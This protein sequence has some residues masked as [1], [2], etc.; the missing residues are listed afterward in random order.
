MKIEKDNIKS[1]FIFIDKFR[2]LSLIF[3]IIFKI[4]SFYQ[5]YEN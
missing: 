4:I 1:E 3:G 5:F 2:I